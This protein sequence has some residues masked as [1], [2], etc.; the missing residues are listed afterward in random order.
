MQLSD[1]G[2]VRVAIDQRDRHVFIAFVVLGQV[3]CR[4]YPGKPRANHDDIG[5]RHA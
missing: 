5:F 3:L 2:E 1:I 4:I